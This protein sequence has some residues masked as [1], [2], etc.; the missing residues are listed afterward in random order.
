MLA[1]L[2]LADLRSVT[3]ERG[4]AMRVGLVCPY[5][6]DVPGGVQ[7]HV[8]EL[9]EALTGRG[10]HAS[11]LAPAAGEVALP[12]YVVAAGRAVAVPYNGS[13]ARLSFG[14]R[15]LGRVR[16]WLDAGDFDL[17]HVHE[18]T[19]PSLSLLAAW[20]AEVPTVATFH[21]AMDGNG[22]RMMAAAGGVVRP[23]LQRIAARI[24]VSPA[25]RADHAPA[26]GTAPPG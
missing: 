21:T 24:A 13:V 14:P 22:S 12:P 5:S 25:G 19:A 3:G 11:V 15:S 4:G 8:C 2:F 9:A 7:N 10:H 6:L 26:P 1:R 20:V 16:R 17:L 18:P 23:G